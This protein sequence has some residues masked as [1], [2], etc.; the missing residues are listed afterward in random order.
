MNYG[1]VEFLRGN[2]EHSNSLLE[3]AYIISEDIRK[4]KFQVAA[5][6]LTNPMVTPYTGEDHEFLMINYYKA[7]DYIS[8]N[9]YPDALVEIRRLN[10]RLNELSDK[11]KSDK[12][13]KQDAFAHLIMGLVYEADRD[14]NNAF[15]AYRN[16]YNIYKDDYSNFFGISAP[17]QLKKDMV[18]TAYLSGLMYEYDSYSK[19]FGISFTPEGKNNGQLVFIWHN[20][21]GPIKDEFSVNFAVVRGE[22]GVVNFTNEEYGWS[23]PYMMSSEKSDGKSDLGDIE[24][25]RIALPKY[26]ERPPSFTNGEVD[27]NGKDY[28]L[29]MGEDINAVSFKILHDRILRELSTSLLRLALKKA[30]EYAVREKNEELGT[31]ISVFN[32]VTEKAD[33]RNWQTLPHSIYYTKISLP[34]GDQKVQ[35]K[36]KNPYNNETKTVNLNVSIK[37]GRTTF[38][39]FRSLDSRPKE[40]YRYQDFRQTDAD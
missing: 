1:L 8:L 26:V 14:Y 4:N 28:S 15:I 21:L 38:K 30:S 3:E 24:F 17:E 36:L 6:F 22:G 39:V 37:S 5:S 40:Y 19:E 27:V 9:N 18:R 10:I 35:L 20:G 11:Y 31:A 7:L 33:T 12:K 2:Y 13:F 34:A 32:A 23:F 25:T 16:A 29:E